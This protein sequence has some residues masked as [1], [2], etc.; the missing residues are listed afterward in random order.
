MT[1]VEGGV[2]EIGVFLSVILSED[3]PS[4]ARP[5]RRICGYGRWA[6]GNWFRLEARRVRA[7]PVGSM[8]CHPSR[9]RYGDAGDLL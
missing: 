4:R 1:K 5:S 7:A 3:A 9:L 8:V 6:T 2:Q